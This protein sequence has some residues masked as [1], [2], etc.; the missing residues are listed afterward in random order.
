[1][2]IGIYDWNSSR[3]ELEYEPKH[4]PNSDLAKFLWGELNK[5]KTIFNIF[6]ESEIPPSISL[7]TKYYQSLS[8]LININYDQFFAAGVKI[9]EISNGVI[10]HNISE[11]NTII[12]RM[13]NGLALMLG[14]TAQI[15]EDVFH[16]RL[17]TKFVA[18]YKTRIDLLSPDYVLVYADFIE[19]SIVGGMMAP[20]L[21]V[22]PVLSTSEK[23]TDRLYYDFQGDSPSRVCKDVLTNFTIELRD[24]TGKVLE[25]E[26]DEY[27][28]I[29]LAFKEQ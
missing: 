12:M 25:F 13:N 16:F 15:S 28:E 3:I 22:V 18:P 5:D 4:A 21:K 23:S 10:I 14:L 9:E 19:D 17:T 2:R 27:T 6:S 8:E 1:M 20:V 26:S 29:L 11:E 24:V 7:K